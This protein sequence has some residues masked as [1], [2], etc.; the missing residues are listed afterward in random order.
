MNIAQ[1]KQ[2]LAN[3][4]MIG[5]ETWRELVD[6]ALFLESRSRLTQAASD[7]IAERVRQQEVEGWTVADDD[8]YT[9]GELRSAAA[10]YVNGDTKSGWPWDKEWWKP[11]TDRRD[12]VK[13]AALILA[14]IE[15]ID[16]KEAGS[17]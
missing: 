14:E 2:D 8:E 3:G 7:V 10:C 13:A 9:N 4:V 16:R 1:I 6:Y 5:R 15:R 17:K 11:T 12:L